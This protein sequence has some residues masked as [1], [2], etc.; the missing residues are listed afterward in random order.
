M[1]YPASLLHPCVLIRFTDEESVNLVGMLELVTTLKQLLAWRPTPLES[2]WLTTGKWKKQLLWILHRRPGKIWKR[3]SADTWNSY[4]IKV[5]V[6]HFC[7]P[8]LSGRSLW[9][10]LLKS[11]RVFETPRR[12]IFLLECPGNRRTCWSVQNKIPLHVDTCGYYIRTARCAVTNLYLLKSILTVSVAIVT[13]RSVLKHVLTLL[14]E[15]WSS[16][17]CV[18]QERCREK[19][20]FCGRTSS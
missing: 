2:A 3:I 8:S 1:M 6:T 5:Q 11:S 13:S 15:R 4:L 10:W 20:V 12:G 19:T 18:A 16:D 9:T 14:H 17:I 7:Q